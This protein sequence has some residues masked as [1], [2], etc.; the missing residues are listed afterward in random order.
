MHL[1]QL[2]KLNKVLDKLL[3]DIMKLRT[4][5]I[6]LPAKGCKFYKLRKQRKLVL[7]QKKTP[8]N[9]PILKER[10]LFLPDVEVPKSGREMDYTMIA[11]NEDIEKLG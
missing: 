2:T 5:L 11:G 8:E 9:K 4:A 10:D 7:E 1:D 3:T 6:R